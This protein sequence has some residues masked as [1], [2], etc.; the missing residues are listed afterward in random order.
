MIT[1][2]QTWKNV[3]WGF[4]VAFVL[5]I[6]LSFLFQ[7]APLFALALVDGVVICVMAMGKLRCPHCRKFILQEALKVKLEGEVT[8]PKC[9][10]EITIC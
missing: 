4:I 10:S 6:L 8:C 1:L 2:T 3:F 7:F 5:L 9:R